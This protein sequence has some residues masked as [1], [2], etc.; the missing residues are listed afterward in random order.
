M[1]RMAAFLLLA[2]AAS[3]DE[4]SLKS[5]GKVEGIAKKEGDKVI[6]ETLAGT[7]TLDASQV[8]HINTAHTATIEVYYE[9]AKGIESSGKAID[10]LEL[11]IWC[12]ANGATRF[13]R[14]NVDRVVILVKNEKDVSVVR[15]LASRGRDHGIGA[16][17]KSVWERVL[18]LDAND[19]MARRELGYRRHGEKW[20]TEE[21]WQVAQGNVLFEKRWISKDERD[22]ILK[23]RAAK[24]EERISAVEKRESKVA[25]GEAA[26]KSAQAKLEEKEKDLKTRTANVEEREQKVKKKEEFFQDLIQCKVCS[27]YYTGVHICPKEWFYCSKCKGY[28]LA[29]HKH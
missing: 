29:G 25:D 8:V 11:A 28:F 5:G 14:G 3:A 4:V 18:V 24:L 12:K 27:N 16:E 26:V 23:E 10:F 15:D 6:V 21:E 17:M 13:I 1:K 20:L 7:T 9:K 19:E 2:S 22:Q